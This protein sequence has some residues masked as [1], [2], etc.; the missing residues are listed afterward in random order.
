MILHTSHA[1]CFNFF[2]NSVKYAFKQALF[3]INLLKSILDE[4]HTK[5]FEKN[6]IT[7]V[8]KP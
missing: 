4:N 2:G 6:Q 1:S 8:M 5:T 3:S 7:E